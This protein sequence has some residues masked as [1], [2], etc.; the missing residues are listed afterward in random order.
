MKL[1]IWDILMSLK[2]SPHIAYIY[3]IFNSFLQ[4]FFPPYPGDTIIALLGYLSYL[5]ILNG[6]IIFSLVIISTFLSS[7]LLLY[8]SYNFSNL[9][10]NSFYFQRF[11]DLKQLENFEKWYKKIGPFFLVISKFVPGINSIVIIASGLFKIDIKS[12]IISI[13]IATIIHN[14]MFFLA[15]RIAGENINLL[16]L[17]IKEYT[18]YILLGV[19]LITLLLFFVNRYINKE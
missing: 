14:S 7:C 13:G 4:V 3:A 16:K 17:L 19:I 8:I 1:N 12:S 10:K 15:G 18:S 9:V 5:K 11:F 2:T 6:G